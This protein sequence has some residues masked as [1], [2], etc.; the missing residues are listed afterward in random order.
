MDVTS[1]EGCGFSIAVRQKRNGSFLPG[2]KVP[3]S[4]ATLEW[5]P[6]GPFAVPLRLTFQSRTSE[7]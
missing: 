5:G 7:P 1:R 3:P 4:Q 6:V 2:V